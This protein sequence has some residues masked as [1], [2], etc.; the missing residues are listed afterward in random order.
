MLAASEGLPLDVYL[1]LPSCVPATK[2]EA[3]GARLSAQ[4]LKKMINIPRVMGIGEVMDYPGVIA[5]RK[6]LLAKTALMPAK[7]VEGHAPG[8]TGKDL[9]AYISANISSD[10]ESVT[11]KEAQEKLMAGLHI[12]I[13]EGTTERNLKGLAQ[14][15][16]PANSHRCFFC[17]DDRSPKDLLRHGH[18]DDILRRAVMCGI[19]A[20]TALQ[21]ATNNAPYY[22][23][24]PAKK[25]AVAV[26]YAADLVVF[27]D[28]KKFNAR[29]VFKDGMLV[30][31]NGEM[32]VSCRPVRKIK[33]K[34]TVCLGR[35]TPESL[36]L[37][38]K[39]RKARVIG[40][41]PNQIITQEKIV[42]IE[43]D[44]G[45]VYP[46]ISRDILKLAVFERHKFTGRVSVGL[47]QGF[48]LKNGALAS[49]VAHDSHN[50]IAVGTNDEDMFE[51]VRALE[52]TGG[53]FVAVS[54]GRI[55]AMLELPIAGLMSGERIETVVSKYENLEK[56]TR[57]M[58]S[59]LNDPFLQLSFL[60]LPVIP[61][62]KLTDKGLVD[63]RSFKFVPLFL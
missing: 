36:E 37:W 23:R 57:Q 40:I 47:V 50:I 9:Y 7:R 42:R 27:D 14:M 39:K 54:A 3:S 12:I 22:F 4:Q 1:M 21:M 63:S 2:L 46:D 17:S 60:S 13:R 62:L 34:N 51:A 33:A 30:A 61:E 26:G 53:G 20:V 35:L 45:A 28:L 49:S 58:G 38:T 24:L 8:L 44:R 41:V 32:V 11:A 6:S 52:K 29:M 56:T 16:T 59:K 5:G 19:P 31:E 48:G 15:V 18:M 10:H 25:G 55:R 43:S